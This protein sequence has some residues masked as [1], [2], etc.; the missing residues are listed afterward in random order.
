MSGKHRLLMYTTLVLIA[1]FIWGR[2]ARADAHNPTDTWCLMAFEPLNVQPHCLRTFDT[3]H[4]CIVDLQMTVDQYA[5][6]DINFS[7]HREDIWQPIIQRI[8]PRR[9]TR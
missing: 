6:V 9:D 2:T 8:I 4:W 1:M 7:C 5:L 3:Y